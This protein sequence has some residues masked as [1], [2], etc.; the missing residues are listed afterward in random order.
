[1][2]P[3]TGHLAVGGTTSAAPRYA[4]LFAMTDGIGLFE[5]ANL[6]TP[7]PEG[8]YCLDDVARGL[9]VMCR[10]PTTRV[11]AETI[12]RRNQLAWT[13]LTFVRQAQQP[14]GRV[15]NH[16]GTDGAWHGAPGVGNAWGRALW[17]LGTAAA[18]GRDPELCR[19]AR[20][21][22]HRSAVL[23]SRW[24]RAMAF[25][26]LGAAEV[27]R[28]DSG[29][30]TARA[31]LTDAARI[32]AGTRADY[33][34]WPWPQPRLAY[35]NAVIPDVLLAAGDALGDGALVE[36]GLGLLG[37]LVDVEAAPGYLSVTP[38]GGWAPG[39]P[40]PGFEQQPIEVS[41]LADACA[42]AYELT[43][44]SQW[45]RAVELAADWF[46][47]VNDTGSV[48]A[49]DASQGCCDGLQEHGRNENQGAASTLALI[50]TLQHA[51]RLL[52]VR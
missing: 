38:T 6:T 22:F 31:L 18:R 35:A 28:V 47:G 48:L 17:G 33:P 10:A 26:G 3:P 8:G 51:H 9:L 2:T 14:D 29:D 20:A 41:T 5:H 44:A 12:G 16:R 36:H 46:H 52:T 30:R 50:S 1:M 25:A 43:G 40:R 34:G 37:W 42:R 23:R 32:V 7:R 13:Y 4:H 11:T 15:L 21:G 49:D 39:E 24:P 19:R 27:L 45:S